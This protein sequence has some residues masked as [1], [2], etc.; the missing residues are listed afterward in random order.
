MVSTSDVEMR[1]SG[2]GTALL[3]SLKKRCTKYA[4]ILMALSLFS[5]PK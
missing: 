4:P 1:G 5:L 2:P 3:T